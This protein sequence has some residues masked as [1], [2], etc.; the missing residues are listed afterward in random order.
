MFLAERE[1]RNDDRSAPGTGSGYD[2]LHKMV[3]PKLAELGVSVK[4][5][6]KI[7]RMTG[8]SVECK[9]DGQTVT[10]DAGA[11]VCA[12]GM[13]PRQRL[14]GE[15]RSRL[16]NSAEIIPVGDTNSPREIVDAVHEGFHAARRI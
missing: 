1:G 8:R 6:H 15:L 16:G 11:V 14:T 13:K 4:L 9:H 2:H 3:L 7:T 5:E 10:F 12:L